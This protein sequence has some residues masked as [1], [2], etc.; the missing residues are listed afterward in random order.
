MLPDPDHGPVAFTQS[1][2]YAAVAGFVGGDLVVPELRVGL[3]LGGVSG[4]AC[5]TCQP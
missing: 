1:V 2:I 5:Q 3:G 4:A